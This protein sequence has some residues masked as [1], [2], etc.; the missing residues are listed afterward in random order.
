MQSYAG[1]VLS[2]RPIA[3]TFSSTSHL[4]LNFTSKM[5]SPSG[6]MYG[7]AVA[8]GSCSHSSQT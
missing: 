7:S 5:W 1:R 2:V 8:L 6:L 3:E 4:P